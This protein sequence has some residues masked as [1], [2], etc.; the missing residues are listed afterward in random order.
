LL[1]IIAEGRP[2]RSTGS[3]IA[4]VLESEIT[5][6]SPPGV[7]MLSSSNSQIQQSVEAA[8]FDDKLILK[9]FRR[10]EAGNHPELEFGQL[11]GEKAANAHVPRLL[12]SLDYRR[13]EEEPLTLAIVQQFE[14]QSITARQLAQDWIGRFMESLLALPEERQVA[15][16]NGEKQ[17]LWQMADAAPSEAVKE[18]LAG[19]LD[20]CLMLG[21]RV[22]QFHLAIAE[23]NDPRYAPE[24]SSKFFQRSSYQTARKLLFQTFQTLRGMQSTL[25]EDAHEPARELLSN[26]RELLDAFRTIL[27]MPLTAPRVRCHGSLNLGQVLFIGKDFLI[28]DWEHVSGKSH[29]SRRIKQPSISDL[30]GLIYSLH[31]VAVKTAPKTAQFGVHTPQAS[32][33]LRLALETWY[34]WSSSALLKGYQTAAAD[35]DLLPKDKSERELLL[36]FFLLERSISELADVL[37]RQPDAAGVRIGGVLELM[38]A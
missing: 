13:G 9:V 5:S 16:G 20:H 1:E 33:I 17:S 12:G 38:N 2:V 29:A 21:N 35:S 7:R 32:A 4:G 15:W 14:P 24:N 3:K 37:A 26:E 11:M 25:P 6:L 27:Q 34:R 10:I 19:F 23:S 18:L 31:T 36:K 30:A 22:A 28:S 8:L